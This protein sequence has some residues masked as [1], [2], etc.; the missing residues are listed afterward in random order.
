MKRGDLVWAYIGGQRFMCIIERMDPAYPEEN[1][2][3]TKHDY[4]Y[5]LTIP[6]R[7]RLLL[8]D[9]RDGRRLGRGDLLGGIREI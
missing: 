8:S 1:I 5:V 7:K 4:Y 6:G 3:G 2:P 9:D